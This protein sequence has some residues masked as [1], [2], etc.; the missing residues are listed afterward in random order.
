VRKATK[1]ESMLLKLAG[2]FPW[3]FGSWIHESD[4]GTV[5][6]TE[7]ALAE[8]KDQLEGVAG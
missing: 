3:G 5:L 7:E 4:E 1:T 6:T 8:V 2:Y